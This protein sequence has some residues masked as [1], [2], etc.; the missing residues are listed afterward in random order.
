MKSRYLMKRSTATTKKCL[1]QLNR[2]KE[3]KEFQD[4]FATMDTA[5]RLL[6]KAATRLHK[7]Y[8]PEMHAKKVKAVKD[9][10]LSD[11]GLSLAVKKM[12]ANFGTVDDDSFIQRKVSLRNHAHKVAPPVIP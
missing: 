6:D 9:K 8:N 12:K 7:F 3:H 4:N 1:K 2:Q 5:R 10:A 11:A